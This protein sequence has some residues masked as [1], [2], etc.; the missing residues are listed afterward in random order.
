[1]AESHLRR[2]LIPRLGRIKLEE[3]SEQTVQQLVS[4]LSRKL[5]RHTLLNVLGT[6]GSILRAARSW[7]Y[8]VG[9]I[10]RDA[11]VLPASRL[12][13]SARFFSAAEVSRI[14]EAAREEP[15]RTM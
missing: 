3:I 1:A 11:L 8:V 7:G 10:R 4:E 13:R 14:L 9:E 12:T 6:L 15:Y 2:Y 5:T